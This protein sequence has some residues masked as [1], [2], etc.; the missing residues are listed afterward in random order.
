[1]ARSRVK[2]P[3]PTEA[4]D[5]DT[6]G[7]AHKTARVAVPPPAVHE[8]APD[9][10]PDPTGSCPAADALACGSCHAMFRIPVLKRWRP[11]QR[12]T[13]RGATR[14]PP[15]WSG[16]APSGLM[17]DGA[18]QTSRLASHTETVQGLLDEE[19]LAPRSSAVQLLRGGAAS[20][21]S[22]AIV[23]CDGDTEEAAADGGTA[24]VNTTVRRWLRSAGAPYPLQHACVCCGRSRTR[25]ED[26]GDDGGGWLDID[27]RGTEDQARKPRG[28][29]QVGQVPSGDG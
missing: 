16:S 11:C 1:M 29:H 24:S 28:R 2:R 4:H 17:K 19:T 23:V 21:L 22:S 3:P 14:W 26:G 9:S 12:R 20:T 8:A 6:V 10:P 5:D 27:V 25:S 7:A 13:A 18:M 15:S